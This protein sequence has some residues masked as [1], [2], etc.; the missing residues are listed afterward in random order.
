[1]D[2]FLFSRNLTDCFASLV[3]CHT[4]T[5]S[6]VPGGD[7]PQLQKTQI[8]SRSKVIINGTVSLFLLIYSLEIEIKKS[9]A[10]MI[11][12]FFFFVCLFVFNMQANVSVALH[13]LVDQSL[14]VGRGLGPSWFGRRGHCGHGR[15]RAAL[16]DGVGHTAA[17]PDG[18]AEHD[19]GR[20]RETVAGTV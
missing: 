18:V 17:I 13:E 3:R 14:R 2:L 15:I 6:S 7:G 19:R 10:L 12:C 4:P 1:M 16:G 20:R 11:K 8:H 9:T 5:D